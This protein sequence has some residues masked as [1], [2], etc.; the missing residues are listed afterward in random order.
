MKLFIALTFTYVTLSNYTEPQYIGTM[1]TIHRLVEILLYES[2]TT[3]RHF[4][5]Q[6]VHQINV[7]WIVAVKI[8]E[9]LMMKGIILLLKQMLLRVC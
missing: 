6:L 8:N 1:M 7:Y 4:E 9:I 5:Y 3:I 2:M